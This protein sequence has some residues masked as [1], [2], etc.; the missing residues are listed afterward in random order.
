MVTTTVPIPPQAVAAMIDCAITFPAWFRAS[1]SSHG[2]L[3]L[4]C[5]Q[6]LEL[7]DLAARVEWECQQA[8]GEEAPD[9]AATACRD[10]IGA[11]ELAVSGML[12]GREVIVDDAWMTNDPDDDLQRP[13]VHRGTITTVTTAPVL[14]VT[15]ATDTGRTMTVAAHTWTV[16]DRA[17]R[18][19][20]YKPRR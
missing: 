7:A 18:R 1:A 4:D 16:T 15:L 9:A 6:S 17:T 2:E 13:T 5:A 14:Q 11:L 20:L 19:A 10:L 12:L 8:V 3:D